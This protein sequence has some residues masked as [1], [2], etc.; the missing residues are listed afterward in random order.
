ME[1]HKKKNPKSLFDYPEP[2][3]DFNN[4]AVEASVDKHAA[5]Y[6]A[7]RPKETEWFRVFDPSG[8][9]DVNS[10][11]TFGVI[12]MPV[13]NIDVVFLIVG[14]QKFYDRVKA[15]IGKVKL[16]K[17]A[18]YETSNGRVG[19]WPVTKIQRDKQGNV[20]PYVGSSNK[21]METAL[22]KWVRVVSNREAGYYDG[23]LAD[24]RKVK[25]YVEQGKP[26]FEEEYQVVCK[27]AY[28]GFVITEDDYETN[29][30]VQDFVSQKMK[31]DLKNK[32]GEKIN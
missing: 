11:R 28:D 4:R 2:S 9:G 19:I 29:E 23:Y 15:D 12:E 17:A 16:I 26:A 24:E 5:A 6:K 30:Y 22:T 8:K 32:K 21:I 7:A 18:Y 3:E 27:K 14:S 1:D 31:Q 10:I 20:N 25:T 13:K